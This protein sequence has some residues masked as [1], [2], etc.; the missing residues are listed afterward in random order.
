MIK[1]V[2]WGLFTS[3]IWAPMIRS[4]SPGA[5]AAIIAAILIVTAALSV[6]PFDHMCDESNPENRPAEHAA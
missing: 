2:A 3:W 4:E 6:N 5:A 1:P